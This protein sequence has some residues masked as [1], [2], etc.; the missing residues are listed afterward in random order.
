MATFKISPL[1][2]WQD[3]QNLCCDL[4]KI[5]WKDP[6]TQQN[7]RIGQ[8]QHGVDVYGRPEQKGLWVGI[9]CKDGIVIEKEIKTVNQGRS[10][11]I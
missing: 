11:L 1:K 8:P 6:N 9:Q 4:W 3:F 2:N 5:L 10:L 7:G